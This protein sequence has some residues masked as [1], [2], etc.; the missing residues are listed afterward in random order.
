MK[1]SE[2][3]LRS[4][5]QGERQYVVPLYQRDVQLGAK[6]SGPAVAGLHRCCGQRGHRAHFLGSGPAPSP[7]NTPA[8][9][10]VWLVVDGQQRLTTL[11]ILLCAIRY[12]VRGE[13]VRPG[14]KD[15]RPVPVH[16]FADG[17]ERYTP[18][19]TRPTT[20]VDQAARACAG[21]GWH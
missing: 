3:T 17:Q 7:G 16:R 4:S 8:G 14:G 19:P 2:T 18:P 20:V 15:R 11:S 1:A 12:H 10:Q 5:P 9:V 6:G 21:R 13:D